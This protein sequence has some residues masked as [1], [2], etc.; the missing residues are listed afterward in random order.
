ME[1]GYSRVRLFG[2]LEGDFEF[3][4]SP[5]KLMPGKKKMI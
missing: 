1:L 2:Y 3:F 4:W 5:K